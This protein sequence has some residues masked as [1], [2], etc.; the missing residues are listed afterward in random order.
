MP[1]SVTFR[2]PG[3]TFEKST[4]DFVGAIKGLESGRFQKYSTP[5][6]GKR[7]P[8]RQVVAAVTKL[9]P[10]AITSRDAFPVLEIFGFTVDSEEDSH[11]FFR[12]PKILSGAMPL[13]R[14]LPIDPQRADA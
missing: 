8:I 9:Q 3:R 4:D 5:I 10:I 2:L 6:A 1:N 13:F 7:Y 12:G 11:E 14:I